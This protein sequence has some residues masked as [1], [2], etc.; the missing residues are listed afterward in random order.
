MGR[1]KKTIDELEVNINVNQEYL[2]AKYKPKE[3]TIYDDDKKTSYLVQ[4]VV[5]NHLDEIERRIVLIYT[6]SG[7]L[8]KTAEILNVSIT[9][10]WK[11]TN[12]LKDK[13]RKIMKE[14]YAV[15]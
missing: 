11:I 1:R 8:K 14:K 13:I 15:R 10:V 6:E 12:R 7:N 9:T 3:L 5:Y 2:D 4:Q